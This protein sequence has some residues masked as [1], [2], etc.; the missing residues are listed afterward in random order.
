MIEVL[1]RIGF[2]GVAVREQF[3][4]FRGTTKEN[5]ARQFGVVGINVFS[6]KRGGTGQ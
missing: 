1:S 2:R 4:P 3:D 5:V 6:E